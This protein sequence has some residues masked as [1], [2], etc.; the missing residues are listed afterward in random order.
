MTCYSSFPDEGSKHQGPSSP[1]RLLAKAC[2]IFMTFDDPR[3][4]PAF[5]KLVIPEPNSGCWLFLRGGTIDGYGSFQIAK[6]KTVAAHRLVLEAEGRRIE[7]LVVDHLCEIKSCVNP[8]H[9]DAVTRA[10]NT[11]RFYKKHV[12]WTILNK[13]G[14]WRDALDVQPGQ[15]R[16]GELTPLK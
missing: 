2:V 15:T 11:R 8:D 5:W 3:L 1:P 10:V 12:H 16:T 6:G 13:L 9:L 4:P 7:G 14:L